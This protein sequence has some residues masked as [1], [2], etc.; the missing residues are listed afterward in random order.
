MTDLSAL[1]RWCES[2]SAWLLERIETLVRLESPTDD[3]AA[4][5]RCGRELAAT[6]TQI[7]ADVTHHPES[8]RG[9]H[10]RA[11]FGGAGPAGPA[12]R[13]LRHRLG[14]RPARADAA[15]SETAG[16]TAP[17]SST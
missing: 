14:G 13:A 1:Q 15:P 2:E 4:V 8:Q 6:L 12:P 7:G 17:A 16:S 3:K 5:D 11:E 9:D 10:L